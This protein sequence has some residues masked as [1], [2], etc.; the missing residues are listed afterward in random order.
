VRFFLPGFH[1]LPVMQLLKIQCHYIEFLLEDWQVNFLTNRFENL[2]LK[3]RICHHKTAF[4][5]TACSLPVFLP[6]VISIA[7]KVTS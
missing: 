3:N 2:S 5:S 6:V 7:L 4:N 1:R